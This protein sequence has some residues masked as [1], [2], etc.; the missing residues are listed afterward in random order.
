MWQVPPCWHGPGLWLHSL[1]SCLQVGPWKPGGQRQMY[2]ASKGRHWPPL[3]QG[4]EAQGSACW[5]VFPGERGGERV[6]QP[7]APGAR[8]P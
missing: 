5:Q 1:M 6:R 4:L 7:P 3:A 8:L 2:E